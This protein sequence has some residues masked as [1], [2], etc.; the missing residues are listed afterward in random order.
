M[1]LDSSFDSNRYHTLKWSLKYWD[2]QSRIEITVV[3]KFIHFNNPCLK[4]PCSSECWIAINNGIVNILEKIHTLIDT[5]I[6]LI[7]AY[8]DR[9][10]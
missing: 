8:E 9:R 6:T 7:D 10:C 5:K 4:T 1:N 3:L 2:C